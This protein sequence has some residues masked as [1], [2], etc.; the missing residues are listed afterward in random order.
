MDVVRGRLVILYACHFEKLIYILH[1]L[2]QLAATAH[3]VQY[4]QYFEYSRVP[5]SKLITSSIRT[6][7][8]LRSKAICDVNGEPR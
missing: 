3:T 2:H 4:Q 6:W 7:G 8:D 5:T 1:Y